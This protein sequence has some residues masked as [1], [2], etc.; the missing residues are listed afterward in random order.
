MDRRLGDPTR[1]EC[2]QRQLNRVLKRVPSNWIGTLLVFAMLFGSNRSVTAESVRGQIEADWQRQDACRMRQIQEPGVVIFSGGRLKWPG[3][4]ADDRLGIPLATVPKLDGRLDDP[5]WQAA[6]KIGEAGNGLP[7]FRLCHDEQNVYAAVSLATRDESSF[8][9]DATALDAGGA[10]DGKKDGRYAFHTG[11][12]PDPWWQVDLG[13]RRAIGRIVVYNRLDYAPGLHNADN[14]LILTSDDGQT[15]TPRHD[16]RGQHF[17]GL[18]SGK[19]LTVRFADVS[20]EDGDALRARYVRLQ[21]RSDEPIFLHLDEVE[22]FGIDHPDTNIAVRCPASQSSLSIWSRG[23]QA[24]GGLL[25]L[26]KSRIALGGD[27]NASVLLNGTVLSVNRV[28][29]VRELGQTTIEL[30]IPRNLFPNLFPIELQTPSEKPTGLIAVG[31]W[32]IKWEPKIQP[33]FGKNHI[34]LGFSASQPTRLPVKVTVETVV[35]TNQRAVRHVIFERELLQTETIPV[36]FEIAEAGAAAVIVSAKQGKYTSRQGRTFFIDPVAETLRRTRLLAKEFDLPIPKSLDELTRRANE[37]A[38]TEKELGSQAADRHAL[39]VEAKW[40]ARRVAFENP[41]LDFDRLLVVKRFTQETYPDVCLNHMPWV[42][43]PGGDL[44]VVS[45]NGFDQPCDVRNLINGRLGP[46]HLHGMD[47]WWDGSRVVFGYAKASSDQPPQGWTDR[48]TSY[49]LRRNEEPTHLFEIGVDGGHLRQLTDGQWS[50][51][52]P[53]Y[54]PSGDIAFVS[55]R[56]AY[57]LQCNELDKD[58]TSCNLYVMSGDGRDIRRLSANKDGDYLP[59]TLDDGTIGYTRWEYQERGWA[60]IQSIWTVRADGTGADALFKQHLNDPWALEDARSIPHSKKLVAIATG[61]H[62]LA[63]GP[64]VVIDPREGMNSEAGIRIVTPGVLPP[65]GGMSGRPVPTGGV[66]G[67][68]G[69]YMT[70]WPISKK[71]FLVSYTYDAQTDPTGYDIYLIDTFGTKELIYRDSEISCSL[72]IPLRARPRPPIVQGITESATAYATCYV[73]DVSHG[74]EGVDRKAVRYLRISHREPW[75]YDNQLGGQRY[76]EDVKSVMINWT[77]ARVL[78]TVPVEADGSAHFVVPADTPVYFQLLD[79]DHM[80]LQRMRSFVSF[81]PGEVR[82]CVGCHETRAEA[83]PH[84]R[85]TQALSRLPSTPF[86][87]PWG[88]RPISFLRDVQGVFDRNCISCHSGQKSAVDLDFSAGLTARYNRAYDTIIEHDLVAR[89]NVGD[90]A[91]VTKPLAFGSHRSKLVAVLRDGACSKR[92]NLSADD[93]LRLVTW[94]DSNA[95]YH[96]RFINKRTTNP[97]YDLPGDRQ[98]AGK[99]SALHAKRCTECHTVDSITR[100]DWIDL[101]DPKRTRFLASPLGVEEPDRPRCQRSVY[102]SEKDADYQEGLR[103]VREAV[104]K[105]WAHPRRDLEA[106]QQ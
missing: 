100:L 82:G 43:R 55:E 16:N 5:C 13:E 44:C 101:R 27:G 81:Q 3:I 69:Y 15:W 78:G 38:V 67:A 77:P 98:L 20:S 47:L 21:I 30:A 83:P 91:R 60:N 94:I 104:E 26:G 42:S 28:G 106:I 79:K 22:I 97:P 8:T 58:E 62:T 17:G 29:V 34:T 52:D 32:Q 105:A 35:F 75:P 7:L 6:A 9:G 90:D 84:H 102:A 46:G 89:S 1:L 76:E 4:K 41:S 80:E 72:P 51:L 25:S 2:T 19:P 49:D 95:P 86:P 18:T 92:A 103:L 85:G 65:E 61:H 10:V 40:L 63:A 74:V 59:H 99:L 70:P 24:N 87:P 96:D 88:D 66:V 36:E 68:G 54:L 37:L 64:V 12:E 11:Q 57:S 33:G 23:G 39:Y 73:S 93:W 14:L 71:T 48:R 31:S 53:T 50:D 45:I 56:C